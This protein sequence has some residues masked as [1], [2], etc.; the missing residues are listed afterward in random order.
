MLLDVIKIQE[1][2]KKELEQGQWAKAWERDT[3]LWRKQTELLKNE[4]KMR[5]K[6]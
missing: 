4:S 5:A 6:D 3:E 1:E 2:R